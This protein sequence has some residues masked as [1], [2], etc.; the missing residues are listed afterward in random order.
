MNEAKNLSVCVISCIW[1][2]KA[3]IKMKS[4]WNWAGKGEN[5]DSNEENTFSAFLKPLQ[6]ECL[7][8]FFFSNTRL[9]SLYHFLS[10]LNVD[11]FLISNRNECRW[12]RG[13]LEYTWWPQFE[14]HST[15]RVEF[16][17]SKKNILFL[18]FS[19]AWVLFCFL[20][21]DVNNHFNKLPIQKSQT[22]KTGSFFCPCN[23]T[24]FYAE[25]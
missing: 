16:W 14:N 13:P 17:V 11:F 25:H 15:K 22:F 24:H 7:L 10:T 6:G 2:S 4:R 9:L 12:P 5:Y 3:W 21:L 23:F 8:F 1:P 20:L 18:Y 19:H